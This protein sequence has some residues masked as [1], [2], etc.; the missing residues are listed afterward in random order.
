VTAPIKA[1]FLD[2]DG[3]INQ[4]VFWRGAARAPR[5]LSEWAWIEGIH[6]TARELSA[7]GY[8]LFVCTNQPDVVR[9][10]QTREQVDAFHALI[11]RELP[12]SRIYACFHDNAAGCVCRKPLPGMLLQASQEFGIELTSSF[13]VGDRA[14]D[15]EAGRAAGCRTVLFRPAPN[16]E[17]ATPDHEISTLPDL[18]TIMP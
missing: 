1:V 17:V 8:L 9:G 18:L 10:W 6:D 14:S 4:T 7:R 11:E 15:V 5:N 3:V 2:R 16:S 13:M 12:V